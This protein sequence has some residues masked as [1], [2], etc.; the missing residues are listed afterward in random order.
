MKIYALLCWLVAT[1][2]SAAQLPPDDQIVQQLTNGGARA[3]F[4]TSLRLLN[5]NILK[6]ERGDAWTKDIAAFSSGRN[7][8]L[9][10]EGW[11]SPTVLGGIQS[12]PG[13]SFYM[14]SSFVWKGALTGVM[15]GFATAPAKLE[16]RRSPQFEPILNSPKMSLIATFQMTDGR[17]LVVVNVHGI[18]FVGPDKL[19]NQLED[20]IAALRGYDGTL[21]MAGDFNT[22]NDARLQVVLDA[23]KKLGLTE[24]PFLRHGTDNVLDHVFQRGCVVEKSWV[25][26]NVESSDHDPEFV[27][28][29]C[30]KP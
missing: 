30:A 26:E 16:Y 18:N 21:V 14:A 4:P 1:H 5:W 23:A 19:R 8:V 25:V 2:A 24:V 29:N 17:P 15:S 10:Q 28:L 20:V 3:D 7:L 6:G 9:M 13:F 11:Q 22:W 27:D 12:L